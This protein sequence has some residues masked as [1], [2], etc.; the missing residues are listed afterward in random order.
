MR[1]R[2]GGPSPLAVELAH[3][4]VLVRPARVLVR[5]GASRERTSHLG[6]HL[7]RLL[8]P[9]HEA[10]ARAVASDGRALLGGSRADLG[11]QPLVLEPFA[12]TPGRECHS[13]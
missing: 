7:S 2:T 10:R 1:R 13:E 5:R 11:L 12:S 6:G 4:H 8:P 3:A 9:L